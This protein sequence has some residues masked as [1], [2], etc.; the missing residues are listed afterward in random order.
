LLTWLIFSCRVQASLKVEPAQAPSPHFNVKPA[1]DDVVTMLSSDTKEALELLSLSP[2]RDPHSPLSE[3]R[4]GSSSDLF[5]DW[6]EANNIHVSVYVVLTADASSSHTST[7]SAP[8]CTQKSCADG[9][10]TRL[11]RTRATSSRKPQR[12]KY[13]LT[14]APQRKSKKTKV[15]AEHALASPIPRGGS[16]FATDF[17]RSE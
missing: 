2:A 5:D 10:S 6:P 3:L 11:S 8:H 16:L 7:V 17:I 12:R 9:S 14:S 4:S 1:E 13:V 15:D